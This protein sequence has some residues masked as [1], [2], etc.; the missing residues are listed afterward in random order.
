MTVQ[1]IDDGGQLGTA[2]STT[3][4]VRA[5][6]V[7]ADHGRLLLID[8]VTGRLPNPFIFD[9]LYVN[10]AKR[11][12][13]PNNDPNPPY[14]ILRL[15]FT[16]PFRSSEDVRQTFALFDAVIWYRGPQPGISTLLQSYQDGLKA[17][18]NADGRLMIESFDIVSGYGAQGSLNTD[19]VTTYMG[20]DSL[21][22]APLQ[23]IV[24]S[25]VNLS[26][27]SGKYLHSHPF[28]EIPGDTTITMRSAI[29]TNG[30]R[31]F[32][33]RDTNDVVIWARQGNLSPANGLDFPIAI[34]VPRN[35]SN[36][37][38][39][40]L[41]VTTFPLRSAWSSQFPGVPRL[42]AKLFKQMGLAQ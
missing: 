8:D 12:L 35:R 32:A 25:T 24:D 26:I 41:I 20:C 38:G 16:Q 37:Q 27:N 3:W 34:S 23:G 40:R 2:A 22:M 7:G 1:P 31:G 19:W 9:S 28:A 21:H 29:I 5:P 4:Y 13:N 15:G 11:N 10:T 14:S 42:L 30:L 39:G 33:L 6:V 18:L 36:P 17:Y